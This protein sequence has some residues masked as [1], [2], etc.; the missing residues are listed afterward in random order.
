MRGATCLPWMRA[1]CAAAFVL[2][3]CTDGRSSMGTDPSQPAPGEPPIPGNPPEATPPFGRVVR[4]LSVAQLK[5]TFPQVFGRDLAGNPISWMVSSTATGFETFGRA[6]GEADYLTV[7]E[8]T[9]EIS[10]LYAKFM[11]DAARDACAR[12]LNADYGR[13]TATERVFVRHAGLTATDKTDLPGVLANL[14]YLK[15]RFHGVRATAAAEDPSLAGLKDV[16]VQASTRAA[17]A[18]LPAPVKEGWRAVC[19]ALVTAPEFSLY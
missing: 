13:T 11:D 16:F 17:T 1:V 8:E 14:A 9:A 7:T 3:G 2:V 12:V 6:L 15:L 10:S 18:S 4:R 19:V 5:E